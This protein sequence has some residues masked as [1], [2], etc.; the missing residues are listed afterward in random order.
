M[1]DTA[2]DTPGLQGEPDPL[3]APPP[4]FT[5]GDTERI[6]ADVFGVRGAVSP[7]VSERDQNVKIVTAGR[8]GLRVEDRQSRRTIPA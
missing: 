5:P 2:A 3:E 4:A 1:T 7:L 8:P 6:A